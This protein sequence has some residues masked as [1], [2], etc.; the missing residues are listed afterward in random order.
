VQILQIFPSIFQITI[1][2]D[3]NEYSG[4]FLC[5]KPTQSSILNGSGLIDSFTYFSNNLS[6]LYLVIL[7]WLATRNL[8]PIGSHLFYASEPF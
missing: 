1:N 4:C 6:L 3:S 8:K 7:I 5:H 2:K